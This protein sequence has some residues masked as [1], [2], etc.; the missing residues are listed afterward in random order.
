MPSYYESASGDQ[1][2]W[3]NVHQPPTPHVYHEEHVPYPPKIESLHDGGWDED[4]FDKRYTSPGLGWLY[5]HLEQPPPKPPLIESL[6]NSGLKAAPYPFMKSNIWAGLDEPAPGQDGQHGHTSKQ[7]LLESIKLLTGNS[8]FVDGSHHRE[9]RLAQQFST[10][11]AQVNFNEVAVRMRKSKPVRDADQFRFV[12]VVRDTIGDI[13]SMILREVYTPAN[14]RMT[15]RRE[16]G[17]PVLDTP[18]AIGL[19]YGD[20]LVAVG[21]ALATPDGQLLIKQLQDVTDVRKDK[22]PDLFSKTG[23][24]NGFW[25]RDTLVTAWEQIGR[26]LGYTQIAIQS[27]KNNI[28]PA[29]K[30]ANGR[31]Y[32]D[33][34]RR[35]HYDPEE[36]TGNWVRELTQTGS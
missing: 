15:Y 35:M 33:V 4:E 27:N 3:D 25:W 17:K 36:T 2:P 16:G 13:S 21:G 1:Y 10:Q 11:L 14:V 5:E 31:G 7:A 18:R 8:V 23:L 20:W 29:V 34:A 9:A 32:D 19:V 22:N 28:W 30:E 12:P 24:R 6:H 26:Q